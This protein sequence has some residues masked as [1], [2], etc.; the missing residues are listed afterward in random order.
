M[1]YTAAASEGLHWSS[2]LGAVV[3]V[4]RGTGNAPAVF[5]ASVPATLGTANVTD[6]IGTLRLGSPP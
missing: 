5:Y 4:D 1:N 3:V 2:E 6:L